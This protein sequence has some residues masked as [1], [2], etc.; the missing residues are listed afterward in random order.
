ML[1]ILLICA[2]VALFVAFPHRGE[3]LPALPWLGAAMARA[4]QAAPTLD[5]EDHERDVATAGRLTS[6]GAAQR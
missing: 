3:R 1:A 5:P 4:A 6:R 2:G